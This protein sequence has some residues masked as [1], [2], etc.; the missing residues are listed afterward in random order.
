MIILS[1]GTRKRL[2]WTRKVHAMRFCVLRRDPKVSRPH[3]IGMVYERMLAHKGGVGGDS[4]E[5]S[6]LGRWM[7]PVEKEYR[8][9]GVGRLIL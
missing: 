1:I 8:S 3:D 6:A 9:N 2:D 4:R 7:P 5:T